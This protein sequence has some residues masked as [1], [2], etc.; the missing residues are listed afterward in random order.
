MFLSPPF[1]ICAI[2]G[3]IHNLLASKLYSGTTPST[4]TTY[5][6]W[7]ICIPNAQFNRENYHDET[8]LYDEDEVGYYIPLKE[9][10]TYSKTPD[11]ADE[12][13]FSVTVVNPSEGKIYVFCYGA[14]YDRVVS[15]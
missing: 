6:A 13:A 8:T 4:V 14:G 11:T 3:H 7:R 9:E 10:A 2:H 12:T 1:S 15:Y 5:D